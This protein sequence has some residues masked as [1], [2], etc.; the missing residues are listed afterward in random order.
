MLPEGSLN[1][2][3]I[4]HL[5]LHYDGRFEKCNTFINL[6]FNQL[7]RHSAIRKIAR[8]ETSSRKA[9]KKLEK[10]MQNPNFK[11]ALE[12]AVANPNEKQSKKLNAQ[13]LKIIGVF[14]STIPFSPFERAQ[15]K[16]KLIA[17]G[18]KY[19]SPS[20][21]VT[22]APPEHDD[23]FLLKLHVLRTEN[24]YNGKNRMKIFENKNYSHGDLPENMQKCSRERLSVAMQSPAQCVFFSKEFS[25]FF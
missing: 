12:N 9:I 18:I 11:V 24:N 8:V 16:S 5:F 15:T 14:G 13:L 1:Q 19:Q 23:L 20:H 4:K 17:T 10:L 25:T 7:Q 3:L 6:L 2:K 21:F 22:I